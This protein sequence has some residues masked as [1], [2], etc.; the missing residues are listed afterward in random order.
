[1][2]DSVDERPQVSV[3]LRWEEQGSRI[4]LLHPLAPR[5]AVVNATG[6]AVAR[7]CDGQHTVPEIA[8]AIAAPYGLD[9]SAVLPD[10]IACL[11]GLRR[12]GFVGEPAASE[13]RPDG[14]TW[15]LHLYLTERCNLRCT[16]CA[17]EAGSRPPDNLD[18]DTVRRLVDEAIAAGA[19]GIAFSGGEPL[20]RGDCLELLAYADRRSDAASA[21]RVKTLLSTNA[22]LI[23]GEA[24]AA[25]GEMGT[26][27]QVSLDGATAASHDTV[28]GEGAFARAWEGIDLLQ[29][30]GL[31]ERLALNVTLMSGNI[32]EVAEIVALAAEREIPGVRFCTLQAMGR[33]ADIW[34]RLVPSPDA[35]SRAFHY[36]YR[37]EHPPGVTV[38]QGLPGLELEPPED[39]LW[40]GLGRLLLV[41]ARGDIFP[42]ALLTT[43]QF[44]LG[45][46][47]GLS[48][49]QALAS[50][51]LAELVSLCRHRPDQIEDCAD[52]AWSRF[53]Q[54]GCPGA[55]WLEHGTWHTTD[56]FC[57]L[58]RDLFPALILGRTAHAG[59]SC[60]GL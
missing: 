40:C 21:G 26:I 28:R 51:E 56:G 10:V 18:S 60:T 30:H 16:H 27:V 52:C 14:R 36:L 41:D 3:G 20:L 23:D 44:R 25:L 4:L 29:R 53:C 45:N 46:V 38:S 37:G 17:V 32:G 2:G 1:M 50:D 31:G 11:D 8:Q 55:I 49:A 12:A 9:P 33:A 43:P 13:G 58:R 6:L 57:D 34:D 59:P 19:D 54:G 47:D 42:C 15:R 39:R 24:A 7:L 5:W 22:T 35:Y 48:L